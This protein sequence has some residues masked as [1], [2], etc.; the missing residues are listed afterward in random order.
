IPVSA[1]Q[2]DNVVEKSARMPWYKGPTLIEY[3]QKLEV[4]PT[5]RNG[6][7][8]PVQYVIR[9]GE[10]RG[11]QGMI[12]GGSLRVGDRVLLAAN[13]NTLTV[14]GLY[15]SGRKVEQAMSGQ[16]I[17]LVSEDDVDIARGDV[18]YAPNAPMPSVEVFIGD[19]LWL[20]ASATARSSVDG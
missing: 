6:V 19:V 10:R 20:E 13:G 5:A 4:P 17:T 7:R 9:V 1:L 16:A 8:L 12:T 15:H 14:G 2:G 3:L 11:Y 18:L